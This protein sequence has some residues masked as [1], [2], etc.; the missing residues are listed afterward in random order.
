MP[1]LSR[2]CLAH[3]IPLGVLCWLPILAGCGGL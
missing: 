3:A 1:A 2:R